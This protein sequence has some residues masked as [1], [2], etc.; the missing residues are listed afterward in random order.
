MNTIS[1]NHL[2]SYLQGLSLTASNQR[3]L[4]ERLIEAS[5]TAE[6]SILKTTDNNATQHIHSKG[7]SDE[8]L[9]ELLASYP[10]LTDADFPEI[11]ESEYSDYLNN[12]KGYIT[13]GLE[14]WL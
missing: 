4:G 1:L 13:K 12:K 10:A 7:L 5:Y 14:K 2:W 6:K 11:S 9:A 3:W 8:Q